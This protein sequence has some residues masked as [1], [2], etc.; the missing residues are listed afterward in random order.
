MC[1]KHENEVL[2]K[3]Q[4]FIWYKHS[5]FLTLIE[6][7]WFPTFVRKLW[8]QENPWVTEGWRLKAC[9]H[10]TKIYPITDISTNII[11]CWRI[12]FQCK[13]FPHTFSPKVYSLIQ[14]NINGNIGHKFQAKFRYMWK[15]GL[16][17]NTFIFD[18]ID[19]CTKLE[20][21][22][23]IRVGYLDYQNDAYRIQVLQRCV[24]L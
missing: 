5:L 17:L 21:K 7:F 10:V 16:K 22:F 23:S 24:H 13:W 6:D 9:S 14:N 3:M 2:V 18:A 20:K 8:N 4:C 11:L 15:Q 19:F 12:E 1:V